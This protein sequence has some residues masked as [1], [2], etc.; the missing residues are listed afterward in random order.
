MLRR[1]L[2]GA[3]VVAILSLLYNYAIFEIFNFYPDIDFEFGVFGLSGMN[4]FLL[5]FFKSFIVGLILMVFFSLGYKHIILDRG[6]YAHLTKGIMYFVLYAV[7]ALLAF[8][9]GDM[10]LLRS[11]E[12]ILILLTLDGLIETVIATIPI[13]FFY[14]HQK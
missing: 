10:I 3:L 9:V 7:F 2:Y 12:G 8:S 1:Y 4:V 6:G 14:E 11:D 5:I 13:R